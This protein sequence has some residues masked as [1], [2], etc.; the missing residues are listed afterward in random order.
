MHLNIY[1]KYSAF[2][3]LSWFVVFRRVPVIIIIRFVKN[4]LCLPYVR[5]NIYICF[6]LE[7]L[8]V[9]WLIRKVAQWAASSDSPPQPATDNDVREVNPI[10]WSFDR[11]VHMTTTC[12]YKCTVPGTF[13]IPGHRIAYM[14]P[15]MVKP[16]VHLRG[17][18]SKCFQLI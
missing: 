6:F 15:L 4:M 1:E 12:T 18:N 7:K 2:I 3:I 17:L 14:R 10:D 8:D 16:G 13:G 11:T 5:V 9:D